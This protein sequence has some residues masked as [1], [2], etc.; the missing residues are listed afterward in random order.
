[1]PE[2]NNVKV[3]RPN[4]GTT[5][6]ELMV[7]VIFLGLCAGAMLNSIGT[8]GRQS[9]IAEERILG[10]TLAKNELDKARAMARANTL[11]VGTTTT[12]P[13]NTGI[14]YPVTVTTTVSVAPPGNQDLYLVHA[15]VSWTSD[16]TQDHSGSIALDTY[17][18]Q[19][20]Y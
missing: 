20:D 10:V 11:V 3:W 12:N 6:V 4:R 8:A 5:L 17:V 13:T 18:V 14:K 1:M 16:T 15:V 2:N 9:S 7:C 19:N